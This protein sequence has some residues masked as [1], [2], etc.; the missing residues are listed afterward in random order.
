MATQLPEGNY[1]FAA[2]SDST[3]PKV[4]IDPG[5]PSSFAMAGAKEMAS[6]F[7]LPATAT[8]VTLASAGMVIGALEF[9]QI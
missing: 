2:S 3:V 7:P 8:L 9:E 1:Y 4:Y 5:Y 6:A